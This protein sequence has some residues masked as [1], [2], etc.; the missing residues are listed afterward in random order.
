MKCYGK[1]FRAVGIQN[2]G[3]YLKMTD[4][5]KTIVKSVKQ[6]QLVFHRKTL[7]AVRRSRRALSE[8]ET[9]IHPL[10]AR[11]ATNYPNQSGYS[12]RKR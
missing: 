12:W 4:G 8:F 6:I 7:I 10:R 3:A 2:K 9:P 11:E 5:A 1:L